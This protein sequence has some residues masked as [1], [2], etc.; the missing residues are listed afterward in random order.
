MNASIEMHPGRVGTLR[1]HP[2]GKVLGDEYDFACTVAIQ[3]G[4]ARLYGANNRVVT[5]SQWRAIRQALLQAGATK[6]TW[7]RR[8][9]PL[10]RQVVIELQGK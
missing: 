7:E 3:D 10:A 1:V 5:P 8:N 9:V 4:M 2:E 6:A